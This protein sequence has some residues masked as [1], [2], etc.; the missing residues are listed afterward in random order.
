M[1]CTASALSEYRRLASASAMTS[2]SREAASAGSCFATALS[3]HERRRIR[4]FAQKAG[5]ESV[6][7]RGVHG[8]FRQ[9]GHEPRACLEHQRVVGF[10]L[11]GPH[12]LDGLRGALRAHD[13]FGNALS[14]TAQLGVVADA[15]VV[16]RACAERVLRRGGQRLRARFRQIAAQPGGRPLLDDGERGDGFGVRSIDGSA[17]LE[18]PTGIGGSRLSVRVSCA[19]GLARER[20]LVERLPPKTGDSRR[21]K[22]SRERRRTRRAAP[23]P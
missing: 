6:L 3:A 5:D 8:A 14:R 2:A 9:R 12:G 10:V 4:V 23:S 20:H 11:R 13:R 1:R 19:E 16:R 22:A 18:K 7:V 15:Q 21:K 17:G